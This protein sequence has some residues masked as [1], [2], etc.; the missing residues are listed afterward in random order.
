MHFR[1]YQT[2][3]QKHVLLQKQSYKSQ[4]LFRHISAHKLS[5]RISRVI[6]TYLSFYSIYRHP[7]KLV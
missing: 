4:Q 6:I 2:V 1:L 3:Q 7:H 5:M